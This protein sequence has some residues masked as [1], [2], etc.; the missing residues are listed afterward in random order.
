[1][2]VLAACLMP[3]HFHLTVWP[4]ADPD[5]TNWMHWLMTAHVR[6]YRKQYR[7]SGHIWQG[8]FKAFPIQEDL[9]LLTVLRYVECNPLRAGLVDRS[10]A[11]PWSSLRTWAGLPLVPFFHP[12]PVPR[13]ETWIT[14]VNTPLHAKDLKY[15]R[16]SVR[17]GTPYGE[18][19]WMEA[20]ARHLGLEDT[21]RSPGRPRKAHQIS[22]ADSSPPTLFS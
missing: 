16:R 10:E 20:T 12:G 9:H 22:D 11:W 13:P 5:L 18:P 17:R 2:R 21:L 1:M 6:G 8:R 4:A 3:N 19:A 7:G 15:L 14:Q